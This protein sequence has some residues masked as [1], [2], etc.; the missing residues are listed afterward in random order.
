MLCIFI[1][2][3][4]CS[5]HYDLPGR[6]TSIYGMIET[7]PDEAETRI[8]AMADSMAAAPLPER[9]Y[10]DLLR[11]KVMAY[12]YH[13]YTSDSI[14][15]RLVRYYEDEDDERMLPE[16]YYY[17]GK[18][19]KS[20]RDNPQAT[21]YFQK[22]AD[23]LPDEPSRLRSRIY[24]QLGDIYKFQ[25]MPEKALEMYKK[26]YID[27]KHLKDTTSMIFS[28]RDV[29]SMYR[30]KKEFNPAL[31]FY[32]K[33]LA[34]TREQGNKDMEAT[35]C[36]QMA[37]LYIYISDFETAKKYLK[38][39]T[40]YDDP[41]DRNSILG[42]KASLYRETGN[43]DSAVYC[44]Q[45][46]ITGN[47]IYARRE[48]YRELAEYSM[49]KGEQGKTFHYL[50]QFQMT[51]DTIQQI[52]SAEAV[53]QADAAY[54]YKLREK[55][56][57]RLKEGKKNMHSLIILILAVGITMTTIFL[58]IIVYYKQKRALLRYKLERYKAL[59]LQENERKKHENDTGKEIEDYDIY[60]NIV[61]LIN[62]PVSNRRLR[63][64]DWE[65]LRKAI[66]EVSP[67]FDQKLSELCKMSEKDYR[68]CL[69]LKVGISLSDIKEFIN[70]TS[71]GVCSARN[72]LYNRAFGEKK[73]PE[74][75]DKIIRSL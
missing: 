27:D 71:S 46:Q 70:L 42:I 36:G 4:S 74:E 52:T 51:T 23:L 63:T 64:E 8:A 62:N 15:V 14:A 3:A 75:W 13:E 11:L 10:F 17:A 44:Y 50:K 30:A 35:V 19:Y 33:A 40:D 58:L 54:N 18:V 24:Y 72:K 53:A 6:L 12:T 29:G 34:L 37:K 1:I 66:N 43:I 73:H 49:S 22:A 41:Y 47:D 9:M 57:I 45:K 31:H 59:V 55:E 26:S 56:I 69:L 2:L 65:E 32:N 39:S 68:L 5:R 7:D 38:I 67:D 60:K 25:V 16:V 28:L 21:D 48:A 20:L 61:Y